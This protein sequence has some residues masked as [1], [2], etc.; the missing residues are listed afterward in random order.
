[1][2][3]IW[4]LRDGQPVAMSVTIGSSDGRMTEVTGE[5][6]APGLPIITASSGTKP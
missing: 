2:R 5:G 6:L 3:Q 1:V 4:V